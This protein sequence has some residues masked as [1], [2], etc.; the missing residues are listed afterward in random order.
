MTVMHAQSNLPNWLLTTMDLST[1]THLP[2]LRNLL[3]YRMHELQHDVHAAHLARR[4]TIGSATA[5]EV[6]DRKEQASQR[7]LSDVDAA[8]EQRD[9]AELADAAAALMRLNEGAYGDCQ[10]CGE[11]VPLQR[12][13][14]QPAAKRCAA[15]QAAF[16][17]H[18]A[19]AAYSG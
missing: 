6:T 3:I 2:T 13:L 8:Q 1:Q 10:D 14:V 7:Q 9:L 11:P 12:L 15:C 4:D 18:A 17:R 19:T 16:E 5:G